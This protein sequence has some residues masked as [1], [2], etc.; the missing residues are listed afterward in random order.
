MLWL[1]RAH[2]RR[3]HE[4]L[5]FGSFG[6]YAGRLFV[7]GA[8]ERSAGSPTPGISVPGYPWT[9]AIFVLVSLYVVISSVLA[10]PRNVSMPLSVSA[11]AFAG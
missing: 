2:R 6:E 5:G 11:A 7:Y 8:R 1:L 9:P 10:N 3:V 4:R